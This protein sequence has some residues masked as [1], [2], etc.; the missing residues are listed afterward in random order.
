MRVRF[1][2]PAYA[3]EQRTYGEVPESFFWL[4][5]PPGHQNCHDRGLTWTQY[6]GG[7]PT[8]TPRGPPIA[9]YHYNAKKGAGRIHFRFAGKQLKGIE[10]VESE[11]PAQRMVALVEGTLIDLERPGSVRPS[12]LLAKKSA[13]CRT[14]ADHRACFGVS[15]LDRA[16]FDGAGDGLPIGRIGEGEDGNAS[17]GPPDFARARR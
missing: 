13:R 5:Q 17:L 12:P 2:L 1:P 4:S 14:T 9:A 16:I 15:E 7:D 11:P 8:A 6:W 10:K 3:Y